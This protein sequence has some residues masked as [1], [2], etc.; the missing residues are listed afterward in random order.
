M[1]L[2]NKTKQAV[3]D[4]LN[5]SNL[6]IDAIYYVMKEVM[7]AVSVTYNETLAKEEAQERK[8]EKSLEEKEVMDFYMDPKDA[9]ELLGL[10]TENNNEEEQNS[11]SSN[12]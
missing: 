7:E 4:L 6:P 5:Q 3:I 10:V 12:D 9:D 8:K 11:S 1:L 2:L